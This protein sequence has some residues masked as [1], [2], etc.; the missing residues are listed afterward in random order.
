MRLVKIVVGDIN[1]LTDGYL[2]QKKLEFPKEN[3]PA[4]HCSARHRRGLG[5]RSTLGLTCLESQEKKYGTPNLPLSSFLQDL[6]CP[7]NASMS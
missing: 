7:I 4:R 6:L 1:Q 3:G 2:Y 5:N